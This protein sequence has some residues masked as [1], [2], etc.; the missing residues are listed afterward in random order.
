M[1]ARSFLQAGRWGVLF[2]SGL[3][4]AGA[5][6]SAA[7]P[8][9]EAPAAPTRTAAPAGYYVDSVQAASPRPVWSDASDG[10]FTYK[11]R[12][13]FPDS[14]AARLL[15]IAEATYPPRS[16]LVRLAVAKGYEMGSDTAGVPLWWCSGVGERRIPYAVTAGALEHYLNLTRL[17][18]ER[19]FREAG[20]R[21]LFYSELLY[22]A[23]IAERDSFI[24]NGTTYAGVHVAHLNLA[25]TYDDGTFLPL[26]EARRIVV[27]SADGS[28][29]AVE[30]DG[31]AEEKV[32]IST[33]RGIGRKEQ[34]LH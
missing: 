11:L 12:R 18:R 34:L 13:G 16:L 15:G 20:T 31:A 5:L 2:V 4:S 19:A 25:W 24:L 10:E 32:S 23:T 26:T 30:G 7:A 3:L 1:A 17:Y 14:T 29:L 27:L 6:A 9:A 8:H 28:V 21:P 22:R 33:H